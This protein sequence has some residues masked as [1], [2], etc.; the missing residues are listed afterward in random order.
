MLS[1]RSVRIKVIQHLYMMDRDKDLS[2]KECI[3]SYNHAIEQVYVLYL[4]N[5]YILM[6]VARESLEDK[7]KRADKYIKKKEDTGFKARLYEN[8]LIQSLVKNTYFQEQAKAHFFKEKVNDDIIQRIYKSFSSSKFY[9]D[10]VYK[11]DAVSDLDALLELYRYCRRDEYF[12]EMMEDYAYQWLDDKSLIIG[13]VKKAVKALPTRGENLKEQYPDGEKV[14]DF[15]LS[16]LK[17]AL[18]GADKYEAMLKPVIDNWD[19]DRLAL[20]DYIILKLGAIEFL[21]FDSIHTNV[22]IVEYVELA[23]LYSTERS[24]T[25]VNGVLDKLLGVLEAEGKVHKQVS[26][27][28]PSAS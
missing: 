24:K 25:F 10:Y 5:L 28:K 6:R 9:K 26:G 8:P 11:E 1:R 20:I 15:G 3:K 4:Y 22:T 19:I 21:E 18:N 23:K 17:H 7:K 16:L 27:T 13:A 14:T 12:G 2:K